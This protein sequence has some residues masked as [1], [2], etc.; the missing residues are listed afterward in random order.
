MARDANRLV[1][2]DPLSK[3]YPK[4]AEVSEPEM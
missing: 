4:A 1:L 3:T 2:D